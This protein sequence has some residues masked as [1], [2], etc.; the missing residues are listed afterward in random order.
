MAKRRSVLD[1]YRMKESGEKVAW[2]AAYDAPT[3]A[4]SPVVGNSF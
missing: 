3:A 2:I 1:F 4:L